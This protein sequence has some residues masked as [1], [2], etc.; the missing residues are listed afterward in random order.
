MKHKQKCENCK[1]P[2]PKGSE[3]YIQTMKV[4]E[5]CFNKLKISK[6]NNDKGRKDWLAWLTEE[7]KE[8]L[9]REL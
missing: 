4:C 1:N 5:R 6:R 7:N 8:K 3:A 9:I 2:I